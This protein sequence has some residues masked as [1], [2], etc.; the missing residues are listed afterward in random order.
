MALGS[1]LHDRTFG[2]YLGVNLVFP[3]RVLVALQPQLA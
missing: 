1:R 2:H 3:E